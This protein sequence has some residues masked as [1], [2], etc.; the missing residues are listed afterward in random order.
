[1]MVHPNDP[2]LKKHQQESQVFNTI[3]DYTVSVQPPWA[4]W[5]TVHKHS[6]KTNYSVAFKPDRVGPGFRVL[7]LQLCC[8]AGHNSGQ[9]VAKVYIVPTVCLAEWEGQSIQY[10]HCTY[11]ENHSWDRA[12]QRFSSP[13]H[14]HW[15]LKE[16]RWDL[17]PNLWPILY[18]LL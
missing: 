2:L 5:D 9:I 17:I 15:A 11:S 18:A 8:L 10:S 14:A 7:T 1:M 6:S 13:S 16:W 4:T 3:L 12:F